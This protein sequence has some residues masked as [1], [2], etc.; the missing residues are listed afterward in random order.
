[1]GSRIDGQ[2]ASAA[3]KAVVADEWSV[4][5]GGVAAVLAQC[6][7]STPMHAATGT[8]VVAAVENANYDLVV[9]GAI[10]DLTPAKIV[11]RLRALRPD[12]RVLVLLEAQG[13]SDAIDVLDAGADAVLSRSASEVDLR[14]ATVRLSLGQRYVSPGLLAAAFGR[15]PTTSPADVVGLTEREREVLRQ[16]ADGRSNREIADALF[17]GEATVKT[18]L[19]NIYDKLGVANRVQAVAKVHELDLLA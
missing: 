6:G 12:V 11:E 15:A 19:G 7:V 2:G 18:H 9:I 8:E 1:M 4:L 10:P 3:V 5:R 16:L 14:E 17:I 13:R